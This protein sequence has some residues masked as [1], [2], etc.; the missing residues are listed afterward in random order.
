[1]RL[2]LVL[3][4]VGLAG[5]ATRYP[6]GLSE[7]Q[8]EALSPDKQVEYTARQ[9]ELDA[10][11]QELAMERQLERE[12]RAHERQQQEMARAREYEARLQERYEHAMYGDVVRVAVEGGSL[13]Y[14]KSLHPYHPVSFELIRGERKSV[15]FSTEG[16]AGGTIRFDVA[17]SEDG[18]SLIFNEDSVDRTVMVNRN[19]DEG[20]TYMSKGNTQ[21]GGFGLAGATFFVKY[22][23]LPGSPERVIIEHR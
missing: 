14:Y 17:L 6:M 1:M 23:D 8:W 11:Q 15:M 10:R 18:G 20:Q 7:D 4:L 2:F 21:Q 13:V 3:V 22:K 19:W 9:A 12:R 16:S 5:C